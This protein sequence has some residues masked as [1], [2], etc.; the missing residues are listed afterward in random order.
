LGI[1]PICLRRFRSARVAGA[2]VYRLTPRQSISTGLAE[3]VTLIATVPA[4]TLAKLAN[5]KPG[6]LFS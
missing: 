2:A 4:C 5:R 1:I 6:V 3:L